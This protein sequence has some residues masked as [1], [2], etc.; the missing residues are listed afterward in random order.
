MQW[1]KPG[2]YVSGDVALDNRGPKLRLTV[3][4]RGA[5][6]DARSEDW[7]LR[8]SWTRVTNLAKLLGAYY[9][10]DGSF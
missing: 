8:E 9:N 5:W 2:I 10:G 6:V 4:P 7:G 1:S 3:F